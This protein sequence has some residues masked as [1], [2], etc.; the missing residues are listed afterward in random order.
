[1]KVALTVKWKTMLAIIGT[2]TLP[3]DTTKADPAAAE[4]YL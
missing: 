4:E 3:L 2:F 1:M